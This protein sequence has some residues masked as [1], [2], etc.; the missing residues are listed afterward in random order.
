MKFPELEAEHIKLIQLSDA[1]LRDMLEYS[2][3]PL[4]YQFLEFPPQ[5]SEQEV[6]DYLE[7]L[8]QRTNSENAHYWFIFHKKDKKVIGSFGVHDIDWRKKAAEIS[9][10]IA[11]RYWGQGLFQETARAVLEYVF[12][13]QGF[14]RVFA[15]TM[16]ENIP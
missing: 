2:T 1:Y 6:K 15:T 9:Y 5:T 14:Y 4:F 10:G 3:D 8:K 16:E 11:S 13:E 7:K 12:E